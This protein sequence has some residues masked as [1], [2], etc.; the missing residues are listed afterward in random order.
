MIFGVVR[1]P[2]LYVHYLFSVYF[3]RLNI[4]IL[5]QSKVTHRDTMGNKYIQILND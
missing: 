1:I 2:E 4:K 3:I 5:K